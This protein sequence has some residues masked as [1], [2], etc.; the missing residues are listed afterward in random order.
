M[1]ILVTNDDGVEAAG[2]DALAK[3][4]SSRHEVWVFAPDRERSGISHALTLGRPGKVRRLSER[5]YSCSGSPA[6]C[7]VLALLGALGPAPELVVSGINRGPNLGTDIVYSGT[8]GAAREAVL[9]GI[10]GIALSCAT[11]EEQP[12]YGAAAGFVLRELERLASAC[13]DEAFVNVN[14][15]SSNDADL[16]A[17]WGLPSSRIY[18]NAV[19]SFEGPDGLGYFF[20]MGGGSDFRGPDTSDSAI[21]ASGRISVSLV[22]A[23][24]QVPAGYAPGKSFS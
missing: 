16:G 8:C 15:P 11:R 1:R 18:G 14:A 19:K 2:I 23:Q 10:P 17:I 12:R 13:S 20:L 21:V 24:P 7:V 5:R 4:L 3:A 22:L 9:S 6:D